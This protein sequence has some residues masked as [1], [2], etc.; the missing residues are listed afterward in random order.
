MKSYES[1]LDRYIS[2]VNFNKELKLRRSIRES[3]AE[4]TCKRKNFVVDCLVKINNLLR[5]KG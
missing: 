3:L 5:S 2:N 4:N 1:M